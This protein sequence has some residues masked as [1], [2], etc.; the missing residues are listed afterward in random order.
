MYA[1]EQGQEQILCEST[2]VKHQIADL[3][4]NLLFLNCMIQSLSQTIRKEWITRFDIGDYIDELK[5]F[6]YLIKMFS[7]EL[8]TKMYALYKTLN[9]EYFNLKEQ[10]EY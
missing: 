2:E 10:D 1:S 5:T 4:H 9:N 3:Q 7:K 8:D 6:D